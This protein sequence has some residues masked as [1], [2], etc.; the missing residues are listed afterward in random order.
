MLECLG[1]ATL[2]TALLSLFFIRPR[3]FGTS[4]NSVDASNIFGK[5]DETSENEASKVS[6]K[7]DD[8]HKKEN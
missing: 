8:L 1:M 7:K 2:V 5:E 4:L 6:G 3:P